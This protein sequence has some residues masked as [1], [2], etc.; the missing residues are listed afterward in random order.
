MNQNEAIAQT[1]NQLRSPHIEMYLSPQNEKYLRIL[2]M[3]LNYNNPEHWGKS[4]LTDRSLMLEQI[5]A[6]NEANAQ[7]LRQSD[8]PVSPNQSTAKNKHNSEF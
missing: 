4:P 6:E 5:K 7:S 3:A 1:T 2:T 8:V